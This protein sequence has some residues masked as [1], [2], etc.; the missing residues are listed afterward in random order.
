MSATKAKPADRSEAAP[1]H[2][3][4][5]GDQLY[6][7]H[8]VLRAVIHQLHQAETGQVCDADGEV[9]DAGRALRVAAAIIFKMAVLVSCCKVI[10][11]GED[12]QADL[13][14]MDERPVGAIQ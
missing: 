4:A 10:G 9:H 3:R 8:A 6:N 7:A 14:A 1:H 2:G 11:E 12:E 5:V 13:Q